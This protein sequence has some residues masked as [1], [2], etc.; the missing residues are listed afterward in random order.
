CSVLSSVQNWLKMPCKTKRPRVDWRGPR[1]QHSVQANLCTR[2]E[3]STPFG[4][5]ARLDLWPILWT[6]RVAMSPATAS[7]FCRSARW[8]W[9]TGRRV[10]MNM[11]RRVESVRSHCELNCKAP[12]YPCLG[13]SACKA[14]HETG[15][16][17]D[18]G[19]QLNGGRICR[20]HLES[21]PS[22]DA[23]WSLITYDT[24]NYYLVD[25]PM[26]RCSIGDRSA[27]LVYNQDSP[28]DNHIQHDSPGR[29]RRTT[30]CLP[31]QAT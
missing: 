7:A 23:Y 24:S 1:W 12:R 15:Y 30:G 27:G 29:R 17:D 13:T 2:T 18:R 10:P 26:D 9:S 31:R 11:T 4:Y 8:Q 16:V 21:T 20:L 3:R 5:R 25:N 28:L 14:I 22:V 19:E 6:A